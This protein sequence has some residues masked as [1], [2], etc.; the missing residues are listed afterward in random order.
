LLDDPVFFE[1]FVPFFD[2][3]LGRPSTPLETYL[4]LMFVK[5]R[6]RLGYQKVASEAVGRNHLATVLPHGA[7]PRF[8]DT[9][10][11]VITATDN[12]VG[13]AKR[14]RDLPSG[15]APAKS[16][17]LEGAEHLLTGR[18]HATRAARSISACRSPS[19]PGVRPN[20]ARHEQ[21]LG[22]EEPRS[23]KRSTLGSQA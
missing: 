15:A 17:S 16:C 12:T 4:R 1:P 14:E 10:T 13:I 18:N 20:R 21:R 19:R 3:R 23:R 22:R 9:F 6:C 5:V 8:T 7:L 11:V 2:A